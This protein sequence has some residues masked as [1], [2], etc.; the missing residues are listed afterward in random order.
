MA[1]DPTLG[2]IILTISLAL[3]TLAGGAAGQKAL[4]RYFAKAAA[5][6]KQVGDQTKREFTD[7]EQARKFLADQLRDK[8]EELA[9]IRKSERELLRNQA[10]TSRQLGEMTAQIKALGLQ[11]D[12]LREQAKKWGT[13]L[14]EM[15]KE[16]D[17]YREAKHDTDQRVTSELLRVQLLERENKELRK[18][19]DQTKGQ[20]EAVLKGQVGKIDG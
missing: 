19:L 12:E 2:Y 6:A 3:I 7:N 18:D 5:D 16:R 9:E 1:T 14:A 17:Y 4:D 8:E 20:L 15:K 13:D 10:D 11:V